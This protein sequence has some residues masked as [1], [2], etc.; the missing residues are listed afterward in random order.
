M[1]RPPRIASLLAAGTEIVCAM[2]LADRLVAISHECD[3]PP[4]VLDRPR[5]TRLTLDPAADSRAIDDQVRE[6]ARQGRPLYEIDVNRLAALRPDVIL[7]QAHCDVCA[8]SEDAVRSAI[9]GRPELARTAVVALNPTS[10]E[11]VLDD[12]LRVGRAIDAAA[13]GSALHDSLAG[14]IRAVRNR[15][16]ALP[17]LRRPRVACIEWIDPLMVAANWTPQLVEAAGGRHDLT[18]AG[19]RSAYAD[20]EVVRRFDPE[21]IVVM[22]CGFDLNRA[23][24]EA[25]KLERLP[26]WSGLTAVRLDQVW[27]ADGNAFFNRAGPRLA[28]SVEILSKVLHPELMGNPPVAAVRRRAAAILD[29][30]GA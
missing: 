14:R 7:T 26:G 4:E 25:Q 1:S 29:T 13:S 15:T 18:R 20:W 19:D 10:L 12:V 9:T 21:V 30:T 6:H 17:P 22:P 24:R 28:D 11:A 2:G 27:A 5:V 3:Y 23:F 8:V 16:A